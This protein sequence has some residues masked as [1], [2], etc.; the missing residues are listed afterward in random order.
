MGI[1]IIGPRGTVFPGRQYAPAIDVRKKWAH[2]W[3]YIPEFRLQQAILSSGASDQ[4][5]AQFAYRYG[6]IKHPWQTRFF[7]YPSLALRGWW[8]RIRY[9]G[10][11]TGQNVAW[12]GRVATEDRRLDGA[13]LVRSGEQVWQAW[14]AGR[15]LQKIA[16]SE[17]YWDGDPVRRIG[18]TP[19]INLRDDAGT[20][21]GNRSADP[22]DAEEGE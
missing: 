7:D 8:I 5:G 3:T 18:W 2:P 13:D 20:L 1:T 22:I 12:V 10:D 14:G 11:G 9:F 4:T 6:R 15:L 17:S 21:V 19:S 16:I